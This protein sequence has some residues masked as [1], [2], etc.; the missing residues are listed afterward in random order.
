MN[1]DNSKISKP[2]VLTLNHTDEIY[3]R[4]FE[5]RVALPNLNIYYACKNIKITYN[6][7][8][9]KISDPTWNDKFELPDGSKF[10]LDIQEYFEYILKK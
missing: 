6:N 5:K 7:N 9:F 3:L 8:K 10:V 1:T 2:H 4:T